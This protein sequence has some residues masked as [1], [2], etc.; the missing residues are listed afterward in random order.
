MGKV[1]CASGIREVRAQLTAML[2]SVGTR[3]FGELLYG[4]CLDVTVNARSRAPIKTGRL[5]GG[6]DV[7]RRSGTFFTIQSIALNPLT[8]FDYAYLQ[9]EN[10]DYHHDVGE[11]H[12]LENALK[13]ELPQLEFHIRR[14]IENARK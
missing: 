6:I 14:A 12:Y 10:D 1:S 9:H 2:K 8:G 5:M 4:F 7:H 3:S 13:E 11:A